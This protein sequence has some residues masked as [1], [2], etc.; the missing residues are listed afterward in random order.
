MRR[1]VIVGL[2][3]GLLI[4]AL[5]WPAA[6]Q[7][8]R[9]TDERGQNAYV[10]GIQNVPERFRAT[11]VPLGMRNAPAAPV[12]APAA[13]APPA[14]KPSGA[15]VL[16][17]TPGQPIMVDATINGGSTVKL[18]LDTGA[19][20]T[21]V[22]PRALTAAGV[23]ITKPVA[24]GNITGA[25]GTDRIDFVIVDSLAVGTAQVTKLPIG[26]YELAG[27]AAGD[28]LLG[29]DFLDQFNMEIDATKGEVRLAPK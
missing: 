29:R 4:A 28:G 24:T 27:S 22:S 12:T 8:Y 9:Y 19:D 20:R 10:D 3:L 11:A 15:A 21:L 16:K 25:T 23:T 17:Y 18:L 6:A 1:A 5:S 2:V 7:V 26:S 14:G 13:G